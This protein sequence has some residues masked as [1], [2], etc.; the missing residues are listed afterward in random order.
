MHSHAHAHDHDHGHGH[1]HHA[2][3]HFGRAFA[4]GTG[5]NVGFVVIEAIFGFIGNSTALMADAAHNL[6]D[7]L[8]LL[9]AWA[10]HVASRRSATVTFTYGLRSSSIW[11]AF[12]NALFLLIVTLMILW[13]AIPRFW[14]PEPVSGTIVVTVALIG[15]VVNTATALLFMRGQKND[16][17]IRGAFLHMAADAA[18][19]LGVA[20]SGLVV[21][22][23]HWVWLDPLVSL[24]VSVLILIPTWSLFMDAGRMALHGVPREIDANAV[25]AYLEGIEGVEQIHDLH[26][27]ALSTTRI[28]LTVHLV[29]PQPDHTDGLIQQIGEELETRFGIHHTTIQIESGDPNFHCPLPHCC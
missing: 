25:R 4:I 14:A 23:T 12:F 29:M 6:G 17:N 16:L 26:I 19:S 7:V 22:F 3:D 18:I 28:A 1:H 24:A 20:I 9:M 2:P 27:W 10:A 11:A 21:L 5:L 13:E 15:V 8:G